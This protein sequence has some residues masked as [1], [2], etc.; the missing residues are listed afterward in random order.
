MSQAGWPASAKAKA[1]AAINNVWTAGAS[2]RWTKARKMKVFVGKKLVCDGYQD[3]G[4]CTNMCCK[5][6][7][8]C[9]H[10][11]GSHPF[12]TCMENVAVK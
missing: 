3:P 12:D 11:E 5:Y 4:G 10:W 8:V 1:K 6:S 7:H 2:S 9:A